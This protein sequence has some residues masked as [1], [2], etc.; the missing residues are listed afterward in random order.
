MSVAGVCDGYMVSDHVILL[1]RGRERSLLLCGM[2]KTVTLSSFILFSSECVC[3]SPYVLLP[4]S[5]FPPWSTKYFSLFLVLFFSC[6]C[7][8][9]LSLL[10][11]VLQQLIS[12]YVPWVC[13]VESF[14]IGFFFS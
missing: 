8:V 13:L 14:C 11:S 6:C 9:S 2:P 3:M 7:L 10:S 5:S 4:L 1:E 12:T